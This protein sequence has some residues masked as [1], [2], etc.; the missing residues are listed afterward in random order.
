MSEVKTINRIAFDVKLTKI[1]SESLKLLDK[2][3]IFVSIKELSECTITNYRSDLH[4][5]F[6]YIYLFQ[7]N[8]SVLSIDEDDL[9]EFFHYCKLKGNGTRRLRRRMATI[10]SFYLFL[11]KKKIHL[12]N[13]MDYIDRPRKDIDVRVQTYLTPQQISSMIKKLIELN[14]IRLLTYISLGLSSMAR[15]NALRNIKWDNIDFEQLTIYD[16]KEKEGYIVDLYFDNFT[17]EC[18]LKLLQH[19]KDRDIICPYVFATKHKTWTK[20][21]SGTCNDWCKVAGRLINVPT[22]HNHDLRHSSAT[23]LK[24]NGANLEDISRL[25]NHKGTDVT[26]RHYIKENRTKLRESNLLY[27]ALKD[28]SFTPQILDRGDLQCP[29]SN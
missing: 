9:T 11:R 22:L 12:N 3:F 20:P 28:L 6:K 29:N 27:G 10:S 2:Y 1:N 21:N 17:K 23:I 14:D 19:Q 15:V 18:L 7:D 26:I 5:W 25:L 24:N 8:K 4:S 13:P 16:V